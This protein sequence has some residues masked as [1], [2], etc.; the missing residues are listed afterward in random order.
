[1]GK[2]QDW[3]KGQHNSSLG[4]P[5]QVGLH[6]NSLARQ[7]HQSTLKTGQE[8]HWPSWLLQHC[9]WAP[10]PTCSGEAPCMAELQ[11]LPQGSF[12]AHVGTPRRPLSWQDSCLG[13]RCSRTMSQATW[14]CGPA[15]V[16]ALSTGRA[17]RWAVPC[18]CEQGRRVGCAGPQAPLRVAGA[19]N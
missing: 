16:L 1:M 8:R 6:T 10:Q 13:T 4:A 9:G 12:P 5:D 17:S 2:Q 14:L 19:V 18:C 3:P 11:A 7:G 15:T